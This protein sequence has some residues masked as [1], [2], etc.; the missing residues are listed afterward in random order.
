MSASIPQSQTVITLPAS[1]AVPLKARLDNIRRMIDMEGELASQDANHMEHENHEEN[2]DTIKAL[3]KVA[4]L[5]DE[6]VDLLD[7]AIVSE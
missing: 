1:L 3:Y 5:F 7:I 6:V 2:A 4:N